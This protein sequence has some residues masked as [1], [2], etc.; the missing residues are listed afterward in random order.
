VSESANPSAGGIEVYEVTSGGQ[1]VWHLMVT[2]PNTMYRATALSDIS[3]E[4]IVPDE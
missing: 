4:T 2:G 3:G 1:A